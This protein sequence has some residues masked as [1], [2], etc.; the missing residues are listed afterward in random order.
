LCPGVRGDV[1]VVEEAVE[2]GAGDGAVVVEDACPLLE[3][4]V[5]GDDEGTA[6]VALADDLDE[7]VDPV[8]VDGEVAD[9]N[10]EHLGSEVLAELAL[11]QAVLLGGGQIVDDT[12]GVGEEDGV[13]LLAGGVAQSGGEMSLAD[14]RRPEKDDVGLLD[15]EAETEE[16]LNLEAVDLPGPVPLELLQGVEDG[17]AGR[18]DAPFDEALAAL[19]V[20]ALEETAEVLDVIPVAGGGFAARSAW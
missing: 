10:Q 1:K 2:D 9:L 5:G 4:L 19:G 14:A 11:E 17:E 13:P 7:E 6:L 20:L 3:G 12:D 8:L 16:V 18:L 15:D